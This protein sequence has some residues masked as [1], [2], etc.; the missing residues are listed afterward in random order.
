[1]SKRF[2]HNREGLRL[3]RQR[4][5]N[6]QRRLLLRS[7][8]ISSRNINS[9]LFFIDRRHASVPRKQLAPAT[10]TGAN[11][12][13]LPASGIGRWGRQELIE[14]R[15]TRGMRWPSVRCTTLRRIILELWHDC[16]IDHHG[17]AVSPGSLSSLPDGGRRSLRPKQSRLRLQSRARPRCS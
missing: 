16:T 14:G 15:R 13:Q 1:M 8:L 9:R 7:K 6:D 12:D 3:R 11:V 2:A 5:K 17:R 4:K 10:D